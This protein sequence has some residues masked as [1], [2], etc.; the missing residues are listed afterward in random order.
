MD[1]VL[2]VSI[3]LIFLTALFSNVLR[4]RKRDRVLKDL[5]GFHTTMQLKSGKTVWGRMRIYSNGVEL[6]YADPYQNGKGEMTT[7][8]I[9]HQDELENVW[10]FYRYHHELSLMNQKRREREVRN[11]IHPGFLSRSKRISRNLLNAFQ[12]A[13]N[14]A[15]GVLL[16][17]VKGRTSSSML[18]SQDQY[19]KKVSASALSM[20]GNVFDPILERYINRRVIVVVE[21]AESKERDEYC[22][23]LKEYSP[24]WV[25]LLD[26]RISRK[27]SLNIRDIERVV[28][29]RDLD[30]EIMI[31]EE[32]GNIVLDLQIS[33]YGV[34]KMI[35]IAFEGDG[36][37]H[38]INRKISRENFMAVHLD[39]LPKRL[40]SN[41]SPELLPLEYKMIADERRE[42]DAFDSND[43]NEAY[44]DLLPDINLVFYTERIADVYIPRSIGV[45]RNGAEYI[46]E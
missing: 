30:L 29:Q 18:Q 13:I 4:Q 41:I 17:R 45:L 27:Q 28:L 6:I 42:D 22:G 35:I 2:L 5:Q 15:F 1:N 25:S 19:L 38:G 9:F 34:H 44:Q 31:S 46:D 43:S 32:D 24:S 7:S 36:Y 33:Y 26:C 16:T 39:D 8:Y 3:L 40:T 21:D 37:R 14:E 20:V 23:F 11:T 10:V 12:D